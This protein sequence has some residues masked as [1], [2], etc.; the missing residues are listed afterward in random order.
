MARPVTYAGRCTVETLM[1]RK[2]VVCTAGLQS[3][4]IASLKREEK[5][6][7]NGLFENIR[8]L[9]FKAHGSAWLNREKAMSVYRMRRKLDEFAVLPWFDSMLINACF[10]DGNDSAAFQQ[11]CGRFL[12]SIEDHKE[13][14]TLATGWEDLKSPEIKLDYRVWL[15]GFAHTWGFVV[16][17]SP[18][19]DLYAPDIKALH[20]K[21]GKP[22][23]EALPVSDRRGWVGNDADG[24]T[25]G[26]LA[27]A[28]GLRSA[29]EKPTPVQGPEYRKVDASGRTWRGKFSMPSTADIPTLPCLVRQGVTPKGYYDWG[30][31]GEKDL[32]EAS[33]SKKQRIAEGAMIAGGQVDDEQALCADD[34]KEPNG[35]Q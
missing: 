19:N 33:T 16:E 21:D 32:P 18:D 26:L 8:H 23:P 30:F 1:L 25:V 11:D 17:G 35:G 31:P 14:N 28:L 5:P 2:P 4:Y 13:I 6:T 27:R 24:I 22:L 3:A 20:G 7:P 10:F 15:M 9:A 29:W 12:L 34:E